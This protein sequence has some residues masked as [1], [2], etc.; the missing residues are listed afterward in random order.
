MTN[1][2]LRWGILGTGMI[3][4][5]FADQLGE[6]PRGELIAVASRR[7]EAARRFCKSHRGEP[8][9]GYQRMLERDDLDAVYLSL[10]N[11]MHAEW[12][13]RALEAGKHVLCEKPLAANAAQAERMFDAADR[14]GRVLIEAF[15]YR[16]RPIV[17]QLIERVRDGEIGRVK[18]IRT[19][20]TFN[21]PVDK[22]LD[23]RYDPAQAGG[24]LMDVGCYCV[25][26]ARAL[27][28]REPIDARAVATLHETGVDEYAAGVLKFD[29]GALACFTCG[30]TVDS[31]RK[32]FIAGEHGQFV[33]H[34][35][36][37]SGRK[38]KRITAKRSR[39]F[40]AKGR[41]G[42]HA[43]EA[44]AFAD[45]VFDGATPWITR[46]DSLGNMR[47]LDA[48]R[49]DAGVAFDPSA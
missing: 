1:S 45:A 8:I 33:I 4:A 28:G 36:W 23:A 21:R 7:A 32:T 14:T 9:E 5:K 29:D 16:T 30:M 22:A 18:L 13:I 27:V 26:L 15:M 6:T 10:P 42:A 20:F 46:D 43:L 41:K 2:A 49:R 38:I 37:L 40:T 11:G 47:A 31:D 12:S 19:H 35:P 17:K 39:T 44:E 34:D 3:A 25:N 48:L 24:A